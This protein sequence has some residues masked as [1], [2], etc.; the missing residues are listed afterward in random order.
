MLATDVIFWSRLQ[1]NYLPLNSTRSS[2]YGS[3]VVG[4]CSKYQNVLTLMMLEG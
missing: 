1:E 2:M 3:S 4:S